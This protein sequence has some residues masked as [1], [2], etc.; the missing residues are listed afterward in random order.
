MNRSARHLFAA[1]ATITVTA[2]MAVGLGSNPAG[3]AGRTAPSVSFFHGGAGSAHWTQD[4]SNDT[5]PF[6]MRLDVPDSASY[7]GID[8]QH[9]D[10]QPA[11]VTA[12]SFDFQSSTAGPSGGSPRLQINFSDGGSVDLRPLAWTANSWTTEN[13]N[14]TDWDNN[15]GTCGYLYENPYSVV[16]ACHAGATVTSAYVVTDSGWLYPTGYANDI[17]NIQYGGTTISQP[18]DNGN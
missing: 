10:G 9:V 11:P 3:A 5:D 4:A 7:A 16:S 1:G 13:G 18:S 6:S 17:D 14:S 15:G 12:P 8:L 2:V